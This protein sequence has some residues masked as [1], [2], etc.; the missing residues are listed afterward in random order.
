MAVNAVPTQIYRPY[1]APPTTA[2][3][4]LKILR[5][6][7]ANVLKD[8]DLLAEAEKGKMTIDYVSPEDAL[9]VVGE[10]LGQPQDVVKE[11]TKHIKFGE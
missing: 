1:V 7:F 8:K 9:K 6:A 2:K 4:A 3:D 10:V 5:D 11:L